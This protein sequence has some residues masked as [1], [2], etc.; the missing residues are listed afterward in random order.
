MSKTIYLFVDVET[1]GKNFNEN[2][3]FRENR[4][5]QYAHVICDN[6]LNALDKTFSAI[7]ALDDDLLQQAINSM[8][9][10]VLNMH[11]QTG[12]IDALFNN[13]CL[14]YDAIDDIIVEQLQPF[15]KEGYRVIP[16][17]NNVQFDAEVIRRYLPKT[18]ALFHYAFFDVTSVRRSCEIAGYDAK[19]V[20]AQKASN[21]N[22]LTD[23][24]ACV[25]EAQTLCNMI[26]KQD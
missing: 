25:T 12:L 6:Q 23:V 3:D 2:G 8:S 10:Y 14:S 20:K 15:V 5:L 16:A 1:T 9:D 7:V 26:R 21:H 19:S 13:D 24:L 17:G 4:L 11:N 18:F 22:A